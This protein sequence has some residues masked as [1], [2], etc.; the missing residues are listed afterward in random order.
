MLRTDSV[1]S[2]ENIMHHLMVHELAAIVTHHAVVAVGARV[3]SLMAWLG[4][5]CLR[6]YSLLLVTS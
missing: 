2:F 6:M 4:C 5:S 3:G 1:N